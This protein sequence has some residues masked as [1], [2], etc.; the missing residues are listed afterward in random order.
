MIP[1]REGAGNQP[2][3]LGAVLDHVFILIR[4]WRAGQHGDGAA[5]EIVEAFEKAGFQTSPGRRHPGQGTENRLFCFGDFKIELLI[6]ADRDEAGDARTAPLALLPRLDCSWA[7]PFGLAS[8]A[9][10]ASIPGPPWDCV[11]YRPDYLPKSLAI[12]VARGIPPDEPLWFH[13]P[14][15]MPDG[16]AADRRLAGAHSNGVGCLDA[17]SLTSPD[18]FGAASMNMAAALGVGLD[19]DISR[20]RSMT[21]RF[22][23]EAQG[24][25]LVPH[26]RLPLTVLA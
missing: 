25:S 4:P 15:V 13:L 20:P 14:F 19:T 16:V 9:T 11:N 12:G 2:H 10:D 8:R 6:I 17:V 21:L 26:P 22:D 18:G 23:G 24:L 7:S 1:G 3:P 5:D